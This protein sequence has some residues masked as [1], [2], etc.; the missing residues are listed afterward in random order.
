[1]TD[2]KLPFNIPSSWQVCKIKHVATL[3]S[4]EAITT[5]A[6]EPEGDF[7][8]YGGNGLRG[9]S[10]SYTHE[11]QFVL[12]G[13]QGAL[14][15][16]INYASGKFWAS[17]HA[18]VVTPKRELAVRWFGE[19]LRSMNLNQ[20]SLSAA[21][22]GLAVERIREL[23]IP[24]PP[25]AEQQRLADFLEKETLRMDSLIQKKERQ[26]ELLQEKRKAIITKGGHEGA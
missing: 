25:L 9:F 16:N 5:E 7:P 10:A 2:K 11:G 22:P 12:I 26:I 3:K 8:V 4:G 24:F 21:Q 20:H 13:R 18:V 6:I 14:C 19:L 15:G 1:M 23:C 17:E